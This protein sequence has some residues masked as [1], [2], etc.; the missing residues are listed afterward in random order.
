MIEK[1]LGYPRYRKDLE[2]LER[3]YTNMAYKDKYKVY[4]FKGY[5]KILSVADTLEHWMLG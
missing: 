5:F 1:P 4:L 2:T 3:C